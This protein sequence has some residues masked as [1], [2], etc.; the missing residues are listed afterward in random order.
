ML[1]SIFSRCQTAVNPAP[2]FGVARNKYGVYAI[3]S[4][5]LS[6]PASKLVSSGRIFEPDTIN[7]MRLNNRGGDVVHAG[8]FFGDFLPGVSSSM[9]S[10][11]LIW[12]FEP[13]PD[14]FWCARKTVKLNGIANV[15]LHNLALSDQVAEIRMEVIDGSGNI[16]GGAS[17]VAGAD[18]EKS[19]T[20][21]ITS[22]PIDLVIPENRPVSIIQLDLEGHEKEALLGARET[23]NRWRPILILEEIYDPKWLCKTFGIDYASVGNLHEN[24]VFVAA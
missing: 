19:R 15:I 23:I 11:G 17:R 22:V 6:R 20:V 8:T 1:K 16:M 18:V 21:P 12:A 3:P 14:N 9:S 24:G 2:P 13:T 10:C 5:T 7:F 4:N